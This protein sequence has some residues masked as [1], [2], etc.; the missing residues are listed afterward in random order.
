MKTLNVTGTANANLQN[1]INISIVFNY[2]RERGALYRA[3]IAKDL[4]LSAPAVSRAI[5]ALIEEGYVVETEKAK[6]ESG[7]RAARVLVNSDRGYVI[8]VDLM[9]APIRIAVSNFN[10]TLLAEYDC[11]RMAEEV[12]IEQALI[13]EIRRIVRLTH[14]PKDLKAISIGIPAVVSPAGAVTSAI[15]YDNLEGK[16]LKN[17]LGEVFK[18]PV[19]AENVANLSALAEAKYGAGRNRDSF[20]F[21]EVSNGIGAGIIID[22][23]LYR[24]SHGSAGEV[25][26]TVLG[27]E[28]LDFRSRRKGFLEYSA[29]I[30]AIRDQG[31]AAARDDRG[32]LILDLAGGRL[33]DVTPEA[34]CRAALA[35]D[36]AAAGVVR[37]IAESLALAILS[38]VVL[39]DPERI[40]LGGEISHL[41]GVE[42]LFVQPIAEIVKRSVPFDVAQIALSTLHDNAVVIGAS[43]MAVESLLVGM[44]PYKIE[45][46]A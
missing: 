16:N 38:I 19:Y 36:P 11:F 12:N 30:D 28:S 42:T 37:G 39:L 27:R 17:A 9:K 40:V 15:L 43:H 21:V 14:N 31:V 22:R 41:P 23:N 4:R 46:E 1:R 44:Y 5:E 24:G 6:T 35:G 8:G 18:V 2:I 45:A 26:F 34:V 10:C 33:E 7:K 20:V 32:S 3:Q 25:G 13:D 29:S